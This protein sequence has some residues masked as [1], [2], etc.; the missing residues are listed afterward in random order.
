MDELRLSVADDCDEYADD[1]ASE[2][3]D[4]DGVSSVIEGDAR[5]WDEADGA[6][7]WLEEESAKEWPEEEW[8][9]EWAEEWGAAQPASS[10]VRERV[11]PGRG[12]DRCTSAAALKPP[13][14]KPPP[15]FM[16]LV[17]PILP[18]ALE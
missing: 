13:W 5:E 7:E 14:M 15:L 3:V 16:G 11:S 9:R 6:R 12:G 8:A 18:E 17:E 2:R 10:V 1:E 4:G